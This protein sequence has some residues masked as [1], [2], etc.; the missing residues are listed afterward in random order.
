M[1]KTSSRHT[2]ISQF[3]HR[4]WALFDFGFMVSNDNNRL[5]YLGKDFIYE[6]QIMAKWMAWILC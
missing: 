2:D 1:N 4:F 6:I 3:V 5:Q